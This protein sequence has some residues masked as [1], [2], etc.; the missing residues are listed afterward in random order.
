MNLRL[1]V[2]FFPHSRCIGP[3][4]THRCVLRQPRS[5][6]HGAQ[7]LHPTTHDRS[8]LFA[9]A[10]SLTWVV[11]AVLVAGMWACGLAMG[12]VG[13]GGHRLSFRA[14]LPGLLHLLSSLMADWRAIEFLFAAFS[15][16]H[17]SSTCASFVLYVL[18]FM[19]CLLSDIAVTCHP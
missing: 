7:S 1:C 4:R 6:Q 8:V 2:R 17:R 18:L 19:R 16:N 14:P 11:L 12:V 10:Q 3:P 9:M 15:A 5:T 13:R